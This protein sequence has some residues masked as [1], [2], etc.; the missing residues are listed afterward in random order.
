MPATG[1]VSALSGAYAREFRGDSAAG[2]GLTYSHPF[3][4]TRRGIWQGMLFVETARAWGGSAASGSK[5]GAGAGF[6]Y[7]F[8][9]FP[10]PFG[11]SYTYSFDDTDAQATAA[12]GGRF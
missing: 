5:T 2:A 4:I 11:F 10:V 7:K 12:M 6:W 8:W 1:R 3:R 9:R